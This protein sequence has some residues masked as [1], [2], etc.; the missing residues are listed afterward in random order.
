MQTII[1][2][3]QQELRKDQ[4]VERVRLKHIS[5]KNQLRKLESQLQKKVWSEGIVGR[6]IKLPIH[7]SVCPW[8]DSGS[9]GGV[10]IVDRFEP[11]LLHLFAMFAAGWLAGVEC[12]W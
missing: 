12:G 9:D 11:V 3:E 2:Y 6:R 10:V 4:E 1:A 5:L 7:V 8:C